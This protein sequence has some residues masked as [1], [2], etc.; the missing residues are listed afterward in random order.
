MH[1]GSQPC[2]VPNKETKWSE[3]EVTQTIKGQKVRIYSVS[4]KYP[5]YRI[6]WNNHENSEGLSYNDPSSY[7]YMRV[8][9]K[10]R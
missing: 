3:L 2:T 5:H 4:G 6:S 9:V 7:R 1:R 8:A 10:L